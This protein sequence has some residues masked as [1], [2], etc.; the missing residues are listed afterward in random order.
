MTGIRG[1]LGSTLS[2]VVLVSLGACGDG[3]RITPSGGG[4]SPALAANMAE[5]TIDTGPSE[6]SV[7]TLFTSIKV[8]VPG[9]TTQCQTIDHIQVDTGSYGLRLLASVLTLSLPLQK[10]GDGNS[11]AECNQFVGGYGWGPVAAVDLTIAGESAASLP[12]QIIGEPG[13]AA[14]PDAC[15]ST[16]TGEDTVAEF[17][18]NGILGIGVFEQ[19]CGPNCA[20][21]AD[22][23]YY[24]SCTSTACNSIAVPLVSQVQNPVSSFATDNDGTIVVL[25]A[26]SANGATGVSG[27]L[28]FGIDTAANNA[29][30]GQV[31][32]TVDPNLGYF[33]TVLNGATLAQSF[34]DS[35]SNAI[36]FNDSDIV[37]CSSPTFIDFYCPAT[38][39]SLSAQLTG[40]NA[41]SENITF[42]VGNAETFTVG[43]TALPELAG[44]YPDSTD[45]FVLGLSFF[46]GRSVYT[47]IENHTTKAATGP[48]VAF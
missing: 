11:L 10:A 37:A 47:G 31:V 13:F 9:S 30:A 27:S 15:S 7:N 20:G 1:I 6:V 12:M 28:I 42:S 44:S 17:G 48:Y 14:A 4:G 40:V 22:V 32:L 2:A 38:T 8:C 26:V 41:V 33:S 5:V 24:Y 18:A 29:S 43:A 46:Y 39:A 23:G 19:D 45:R 36:Y 21:N 35:G 34:I 25:P 3:S 16:G